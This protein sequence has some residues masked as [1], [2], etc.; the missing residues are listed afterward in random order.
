MANTTFSGPVRSEDN[1]KLVSKN[2]TTGLIQDRTKV[3]GLKDTRR[4]YLE[5]YFLQRPIL[6]ANL[7]QAATVEEARAGQ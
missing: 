5:E 2:T 1:F 3:G 4:Y 7:D 6:N